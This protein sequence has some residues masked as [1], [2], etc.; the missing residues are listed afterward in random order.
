M[1]FVYASTMFLCL[2][3]ILLFAALAHDWIVVGQG[4]HPM[5]A[6][7]GS[8]AMFGAGYWASGRIED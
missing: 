5:L 2:I 7:I 1:K 6:G 8:L 3:G 4:L